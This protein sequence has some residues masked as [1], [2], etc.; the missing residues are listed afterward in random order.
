MIVPICWND[1]NAHN[2][3]IEQNWFLHDIHPYFCYEIS[4]EKLIDLGGSLFRS[5][6]STATAKGILG[7]FQIGLGTGLAYLKVDKLF[8]GAT[9]LIPYEKTR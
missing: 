7:A 9:R 3:N 1:Q 5:W 4:K 2:E 8:E 6:S